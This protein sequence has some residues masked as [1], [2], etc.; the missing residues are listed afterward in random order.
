MPLISLTVGIFII[1]AIVDILNDKKNFNNE[2]V[3]VIQ[4]MTALVTV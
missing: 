4:L 3:A 1:K 2:R